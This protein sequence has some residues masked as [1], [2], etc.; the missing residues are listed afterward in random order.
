MQQ[1]GYCTWFRNRKKIPLDIVD[2]GCKHFRQ[3]TEK[4][5]K[6]D[7][8]ITHLINTFDGQVM[9]IEPEKKTYIWKKNYKSKHKYGERKDW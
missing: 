8:I 6:T 3:R 4:D 9:N 1:S 5:I 2:K 7:N